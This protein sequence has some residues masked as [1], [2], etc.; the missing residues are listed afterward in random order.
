MIMSSAY[1]RNSCNKCNINIWRQE[2]QT[3]T[4]GT[5]VEIKKLVKGREGISL[6]L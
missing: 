6:I 3:L 4:H 5:K 2:K 1:E